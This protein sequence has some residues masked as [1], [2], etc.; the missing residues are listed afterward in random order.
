MGKLKGQKEYLKFQKDERLTRKQAILANC[1]VCNGEEESNVD[2]QGK[3]CPLYR[4]SPYKGF[5][6]SVKLENDSFMSPQDKEIGS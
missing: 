1:Y 5:K 3:N 4:Y 2:C 6:R